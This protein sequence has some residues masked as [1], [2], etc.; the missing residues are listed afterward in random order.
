VQCNDQWVTGPDAWRE[1]V[2]LHPE[3]GY[4]PDRWGFH[5]FLRHF[6]QALVHQDAIRLAKR[7]FWIANRERFCAVSFACATGHV[8]ARVVEAPGGLCGDKQCCPR[9]PD[10]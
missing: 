7:R 8:H 4:R 2:T 5:N 10:G 1:F 3:L 9:L 6:K